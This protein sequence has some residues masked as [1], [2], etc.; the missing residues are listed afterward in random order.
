MFCSVI[1]S[2]ESSFS[3]MLYPSSGATKDK[4][5]GVPFAIQGLGENFDCIL[6]G[7][8][9][10]TQELWPPMS[11]ST[12]L[13]QQQVQLGKVM[14]DR[15]QSL[16]KK[17]SSA[18]LMTTGSS[19]TSTSSSSVPHTNDH[20]SP[21]VMAKKQL[22]KSPPTSDG[23][24]SSARSKGDQSPGSTQSGHKRL[25]CDANMVSATSS[26]VISPKSLQRAST[27]GNLSSLVDAQDAS[28]SAQNFETKQAAR[29]S[30]RAESFGNSSASS[31]GN[32]ASASGVRGNRSKSGSVSSAST[33][34][35][36]VD[37][38]LLATQLFVVVP[39]RL[40][41]SCGHYDNSFRVTAL[42][43]GKLI[44]VVDE[45][46]DIV[47]CIAWTQDFGRNWIITG[48]CD[49]T[50][51]VWEVNL[52]D[53]ELPVA[54]NPL[55][56]LYGHD[57]AISTVAIN[58]ELDVVLSGSTDGTIIVHSLREGVYTRSILVNG[59]GSPMTGN[60]VL[61]SSSG[62][63]LS[64]AATTCSFYNTHNVSTN[65]QA[66]LLGKHI[67]WVGVSVEG[68]IVVYCGDDNLLC[69]Y[70]INGRM[71]ACKDL[72][73]D[74]ETLSALVISEDGSVLIT[75]GSHCLVVFR[76]VRTLQLADNGPRKGMVVV[77][78][79]SSNVYQLPPFG[80]PIRSLLLS[81]RERHLIVGLES[82]E[83][84]ILAQ[85]PEYLRHR[86]QQHLIDVGIL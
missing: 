59:M 51:M 49:C 12:Y 20:G 30:H 69:T 17:D 33:T 24:K 54:I 3:S 5:V 39:D 60:G 55:Y 7:N 78:D 14:K 63:S 80:S 72:G 19:N 75:G 83:V 31:G 56:V 82:G 35:S 6:L 4:R 38:H 28:S 67:T 45:H 73:H 48:S 79:G 68:L 61:K 84:R 86:L 85:D 34:Y 26:P 10:T 27:G 18:S 76:W 74:G 32:A 2:K 15:R 9:K 64:T 50:V 58:A 16:K 1:G 52:N 71:L 65:T 42:D 44:Q 70:T 46:S 47:T 53:R 22:P 36:N 77:V 81:R 62:G 21:V 43:T 40:L 11:A 25:E 66:W 41:F 13:S 37:Q 8:S 29:Q 23:K 57:D